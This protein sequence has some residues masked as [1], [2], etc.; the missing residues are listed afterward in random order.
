MQRLKLCGI[1]NILWTP[2]VKGT[3]STFVG[4]TFI[5]IFILLLGGMGISA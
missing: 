5:L 3:L 1:K 2:H 4:M